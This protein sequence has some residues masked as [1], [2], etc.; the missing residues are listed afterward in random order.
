MRKIFVLM[1]LCIS[2]NSFSQVTVTGQSNPSP[3]A[4]E[5]Y[6]AT[7]D[8]TL[9]PYANISWTV[10]GGTIISQNINPTATPIWCIVEWDNTPGTGSIILN[11]D[12]NG[13]YA[14]LQVQV[15]ETQQ[16]CEVA[17]AGPDVI[18]IC[19]SSPVIGTPAVAGYSYSWRPTSG[20]PLYPSGLSNPNIAQPTASP[21]SFKTY[22]LT[23]TAQDNL[24]VNSDFEAGMSG[25]NT[26][27]GT[28][29][30]GI[31]CNDGGVF[32]SVNVV[33]NPANDIGNQYCSFTNYS[34]NGTKSLFVDGSCNAD[35]RFWYQTVTIQPNTNY[36]FSGFFSAASTQVGYTASD[37][38][39]IR[40]K[41]NGVIQVDNWN[42]N[43]F[44]CGDWKEL[45]FSWNSGT[46]TSAIIELYD[47]NTQK[48]MNDFSVDDLY[49]GLCPRST[50]QVN[51]FVQ[52]KNPTISPAGPIKYY[53][54]YESPQTVTF[55]SSPAA[56]YQW[57]KNG[58]AIAGATNQSYTNDADMSPMNPFNG[59]IN[60]YYHVVTPCGASSAVAVTYIP[61]FDET[62]YP[63]QFPR[64]TCGSAFNNPPYYIQFPA[65]YLGSGTISSWGIHDNYSCFTNQFF[66][67]NTGQLSYS[68][69]GSYNATC[70]IGIYITSELPN[71]NQTRI[72][73]FLFINPNCRPGSESNSVSDTQRR[74]LTEYQTSATT[75]TIFPNPATS[76]LTIQWK[77]GLNRI[78][79]YNSIGRIVKTIANKNATTVSIPI[80]DYKP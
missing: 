59:P 54:Q 73:G 3:G 19:G 16:S 33:T 45:S 12:L 58:V 74:V 61:C 15:G 60:I 27:Y 49:F 4:Q 62:D 1:L 7:F 31:G 42:N 68:G 64:L 32:G 40:V 55:T 46:A 53:Y 20:F 80:A 57:Y 37:A 43:A 52:Q 70:G 17:N 63:V 8:Y 69:G 9:H 14:E 28:Y 56:S 75:P 77:D 50:D 41:I 51:V 10:T 38:L 72:F 25:F 18:L 67:N 47:M 66:F 13:G 78:D 39:K 30:N 35:L 79:I 5:Y 26:D 29:P 2:I 65:P 44:I 76:I 36:Y 24:I 6:E 22:T 34:T 48:N 23:V 21:S 71:G 11:E